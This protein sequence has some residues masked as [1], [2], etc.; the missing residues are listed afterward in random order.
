MNSEPL[1]FSSNGQFKILQFTDIHYDCGCEADQK[2]VHLMEHLI[3]TEQPDFIIVTGDVS[4]GKDNVNQLSHALAPIVDSGCPWSIVF[5]NHDAEY[6][7]GHDALLHK[8]VTLPN[9]RISNDTGAI[10]GKSNYY[11]PV[12]ESKEKVRWILYGLDSNMYNS[13]SLVG[14][15]DYIRSSQIQWYQQTNRLLR[16]QYGNF[17]ALSFF[18]IPLP[19]YNDVW[20]TQTCYG[21]KNEEVCCPNQN[22]GLFSAM[23]EEGNM[24]GV[25]VGH[26]HINDYWGELYGIRLCYGR[27]TGYNTYGK[28][29]YLRGARIILL[30]RNTPAQFI[31]YIHLSDDTIIKEQASHFPEKP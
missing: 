15:Y 16:K 3:Q 5:G 9:H 23:L 29:D 13:N 30:D 19:E 20:S 26:D 22:S 1:Y 14:G 27:A 28:E 7:E 10:F 2:T 17:D 4:T 21:E 12:Y 25:F 18:H 24:R 11:L 6:G 31:T 8:L